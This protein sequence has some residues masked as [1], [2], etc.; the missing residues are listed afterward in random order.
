LQNEC[1]IRD[2]LGPRNTVHLVHKWQGILE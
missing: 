2:E 1:E